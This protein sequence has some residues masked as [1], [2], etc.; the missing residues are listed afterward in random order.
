MNE[1]LLRLS[2]E[3]ISIEYLMDQERVRH[4]RIMRELRDK[5]SRNF[6][7]TNEAKGQSSINKSHD[8]FRDMLWVGQKVT[9]VADGR[10]V[11][12]VDGEYMS[13]GRISNFWYF[14]EILPNGTM[15]PKR[16]HGY[17]HSLV[18]DYFLE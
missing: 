10:E 12:I 13:N 9:V 3:L 2:A 17:G 1:E 14:R 5:M 6:K 4:G 16:E 7:Q 8:R 11:I 15:S 18:S